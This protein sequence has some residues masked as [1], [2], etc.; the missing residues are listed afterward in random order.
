MKIN[1]FDDPI[2]TTLV[3]L[4]TLGALLWG[5]RRDIP[6]LLRNRYWLPLTGYRSK[7]STPQGKHRPAPGRIRIN[8][9][10]V[11]QFKGITTT[12]RHHTA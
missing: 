7:H 10:F 11:A 2:S 1:V 5:I 4:T 9:D 3:F 8:P 12:L 6:T